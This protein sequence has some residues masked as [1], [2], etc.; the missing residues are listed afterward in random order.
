MF[1]LGAGIGPAV[2]HH[3]DLTRGTIVMPERQDHSSVGG[4]RKSVK[5]VQ[6]ARR[7]GSPAECTCCCLYQGAGRLLQTLL[8]GNDSHSH[9][10][11]GRLVN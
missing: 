2:L 3:G 9:T 4:A 5:L 8:C 1:T 10:Q 11:K 7:P 6:L